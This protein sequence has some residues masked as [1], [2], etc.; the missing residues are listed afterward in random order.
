MQSATFPGAARVLPAT[1]VSCSGK[2]TVGSLLPGR[3]GWAYAAGAGFVHPS[4][5]LTKMAAGRPLGNADRDRWFDA[6][7]FC[8]FEPA[9]PDQGAAQGCAKRSPQQLVE[10]AIEIAVAR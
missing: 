7:R 8:G 5:N 3:L 9:R 1:D 10:R 6:A 4:A 2:T